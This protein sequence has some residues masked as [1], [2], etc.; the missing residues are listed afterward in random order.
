MYP[1]HHYLTVMDAV[2]CVAGKKQLALQR[3]G[4][5]EY[6]SASDYYKVWSLNGNIGQQKI[7]YESNFEKPLSYDPI[8]AY[9]YSIEYV[10]GLIGKVHNAFKFFHDET[11]AI[12][13]IIAKHMDGDFLDEMHPDSFFMRY[14][15]KEDFNLVKKGDRVHLQIRQ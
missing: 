11:V 14:M 8:L 7:R 4:N 10:E 1:A 9:R 5:K 3:S 12:N 15:W 2:K 6:A 13:E